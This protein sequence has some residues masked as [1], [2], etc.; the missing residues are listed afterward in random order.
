VLPASVRKA[1]E[2][3]DPLRIV[4]VCLGNICRSPM[5]ELVMRRLVDEAGLGDRVLVGSAGTGDWHVGERADERAAAAL[6]S[7]GYDP[8]AHRARQFEA[9]DFGAVDLVVALDAAN[10][11]TLRRSAPD[12]QATAKIT[13]LRSHDPRSVTAGAKRADLDVPDPY[14]GGPEGFPHAL[15]L[16][17]AACRGLLDELRPLLG[18]T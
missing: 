7:R 6:R 12:P 9:D 15:D 8:S 14:H 11:A 3:D 5:A 17:E 10:A 1:A 13:L 4:F 16:V 2:E 18:R